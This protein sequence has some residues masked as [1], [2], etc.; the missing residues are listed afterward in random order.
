MIKKENYFTKIRNTGYFEWNIDNWND[1][2]LENN[3]PNFLF[4]NYLW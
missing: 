3:S 2:K 1:L 4:E